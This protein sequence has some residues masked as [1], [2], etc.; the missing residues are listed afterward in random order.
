M[1][2]DNSF[3]SLLHKSAVENKDEKFWFAKNTV[4]IIR[5]KKN[6]FWIAINVCGRVLNNI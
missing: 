6:P 1:F 5:E 2:F 3:S 4:K